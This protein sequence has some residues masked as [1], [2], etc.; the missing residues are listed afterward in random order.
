MNQF[1][2]VQYQNKRDGLVD[3]ITLDELIGS[4]RI[5]HFYR[6]SEQRWVNILA[7]PVRSRD[8]TKNTKVFRRASDRGEK[9]Q[10]NNTAQKTPR[11]LFPNMFKDDKRHVPPR[12]KLT[13]DDWFERGLV[14]LRITNNHGEAVRAFALSIQL[15]RFYDRAYVNRGIAYESLGNLQQ[16]IED[17]SRAI[18]VRPNY[19]MAYYLRGLALRRT[20]GKEESISDLKKAA[21]LGY[22]PAVM[23]LKSLD[24]FL[25]H[26]Q[27]MPMEGDTS[28]KSSYPNAD[29]KIAG[30]FLLVENK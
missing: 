19:E 17:Y 1:V 20:G 13:C 3:D 10:E 8:D 24:M 26:K 14:A 7:D 23:Y 9:D 11:R 21:D 5:S 15:D 22:R 30:S 29:S 27:D 16:A 18:A 6:P 2:Q 4:K 12:K 25:K 28:V